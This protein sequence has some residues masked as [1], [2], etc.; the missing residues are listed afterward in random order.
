MS[1][2]EKIFGIPVSHTLKQTN[3]RGKGPVANNESWEHEEYDAT[4]N[5]VAKYSS[6]H[7]TEVYNLS[8][9]TNSGWKKYVD[10]NCVYES[11]SLDI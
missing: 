9:K 5:L 1:V 3:Y 4:G 8:G 6:W 7:N 11:S 10:G 2:F